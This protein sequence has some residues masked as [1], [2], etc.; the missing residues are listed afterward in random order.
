MNPTHGY[1]KRDDRSSVCR[2]AKHHPLSI[3]RGVRHSD[4]ACDSQFVRV[5]FKF[6]STI[7]PESLM[8]FLSSS[9]R[10]MS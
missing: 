3:C 9:M 8:F 6:L 7:L 5:L 4:K 10:T 1:W 2:P